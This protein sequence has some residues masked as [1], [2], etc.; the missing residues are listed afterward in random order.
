MTQDKIL[1]CRTRPAWPGAFQSHDEAALPGHRA[2][3]LPT[4]AGAV[5]GRRLPS[6][7]NPVGAAPRPRSPGVPDEPR[8]ASCGSARN[9]PT[10]RVGPGAHA[11]ECKHPNVKVSKVTPD[12]PASEARKHS[13][14]NVEKFPLRGLDS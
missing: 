13:R 8:G 3:M 2:D 4:S 7:A 1:K 6:S 11:F 5:T 14:R 10:L 12:G 9:V